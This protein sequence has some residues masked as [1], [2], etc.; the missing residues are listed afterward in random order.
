MQ[1]AQL[2][3]VTVVTQDGDS[4]RI[5]GKGYVGGVAGRQNQAD[6]YNSSVSGTIGGNGSR[7]AGGVT[8]LYESGDLIVSRF[9]G[10]IGRT[11]QGTAAHEGTFIGTRE[12]KNGFTYG[13]GKNDQVSYLFAGTAAQAK[14]AIVP[15]LQMTTPGLMTLTSD[16]LRITRD[17]MPGERN[18]GAGRRTEIF[19]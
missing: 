17:G 10:E 19:L 16:T 18:G 3:D 9:D 6:I 1:K 2:A 5:Q 12:P 11:G 14:K 15:P 8:G 4:S 7:A 13:T